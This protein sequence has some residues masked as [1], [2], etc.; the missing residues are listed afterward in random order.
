MNT[1]QAYAVL[2]IE[3]SSSE[4]EIRKA[5]RKLANQYHPDKNKDP[6]AESKFKEIN[7]AYQA[8]KE[9]NKQEQSWV[10]TVSRSVQFPPLQ[11]QA[12][13]SFK[14]AVLGCKKTIQVSRYVKC[15]P[16]NGKGH[17]ST[18]DNCPGCEGKGRRVAVQGNV[19]MVMNCSQCHGAGRKQDV[20]TDCSGAGA[21][22]T[23]SSFDVSLPGGLLTGQVVRL[24]GGGHWQSSHFGV[25]YSDAFVNINVNPEPNM[26]LVGHNVIST[27]EVSLLDA[28]KGTTKTVPT[29]HGECEL[30]VPRCSRNKD[31]VV[32]KGQGAI[33][34]MS[35]I[36]DHI[37][38]LDV[39]YPDDTDK[40]IKAL[41]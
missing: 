15:D 35:T 34:Q 3:S 29:V 30:K 16:C 2:G 24:G 13:L 26:R 8:L 25:G 38:V 28:L 36:G 1:Q 22:I 9:P 18:H 23:D 5:F 10:S 17:W 12:S 32:K 7:E 39:K 37:F 21:K 19:T 14:E 27:L 40:L 20:C 11:I 4:D 6:D 41:E 33:M 31:E